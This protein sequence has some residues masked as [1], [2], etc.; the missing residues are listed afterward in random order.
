MIKLLYFAGNAILASPF[1]MTN[2]DLGPE[3]HHSLTNGKRPSTSSAEMVENL[4]DS[5]NNNSV[6]QIDK[7][8]IHK[9]RKRRTSENSNGGE[10][11]R[12]PHTDPPPMMATESAKISVISTKRAASTESAEI[13]AQKRRKKSKKNQYIT[14]DFCLNIEIFGAFHHQGFEFSLFSME[15]RFYNDISLQ[16]SVSL[17]PSLQKSQ[18]HTAIFT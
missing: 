17:V 4:V 1:E 7:V 6:D 12:R 9:K 18:T 5:C 3:K 16:K 10:T 13:Q 11:H 8:I 15:E 2:N 14:V